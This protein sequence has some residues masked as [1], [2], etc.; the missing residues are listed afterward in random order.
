M[1][2]DGGAR[3]RGLVL[4]AAV[5]VTVAVFGILPAGVALAGR[6]TDLA[7]QPPTTNQ[8]PSQ[9][10]GVS[11]SSSSG[12]SGTSGAAHAPNIPLNDAFLELRPTPGAPSN[13]G[14]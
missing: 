9:D 13:G 11:H 2:N 1:L 12:A 3:L 8:A 6:V 4:L 14:V 7:P 10:N 5:M